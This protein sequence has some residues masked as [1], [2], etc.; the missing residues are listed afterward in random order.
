MF[1][2]KDEGREGHDISEALQKKPCAKSCVQ[3]HRTKIIDLTK[4]PQRKAYVMRRMTLSAKD[5]QAA[6]AHMDSALYLNADDLASF[7]QN[8]VKLGR[9]VT[10]PMEKRIAV[11]GKLL[12]NIIFRNCP[13]N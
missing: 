10:F 12:S 8:E 3:R 4:I 9:A 13:K 7:L 11:S 5:V 1:W 6:R 2:C